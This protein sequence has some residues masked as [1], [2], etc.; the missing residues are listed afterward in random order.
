METKRW[1][2]KEY[3]NKRIRLDK[4]YRNQRIDILG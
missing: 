1:P 2:D 4:E 3:G